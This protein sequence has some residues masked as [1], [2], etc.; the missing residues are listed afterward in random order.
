MLVRWLATVCWR[1]ADRTRTHHDLLRAA[2]FF[3]L[4]SLRS[5][6]SNASSIPDER[7]LLAA[8]QYNDMNHAALSGISGLQL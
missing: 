3:S 5:V 6:F 1:V 2:L 8:E 4:D 7:E